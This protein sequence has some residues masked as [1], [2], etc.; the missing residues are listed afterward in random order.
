MSPTG[1]PKLDV[2]ARLKQWMFRRR[3]G[4]FATASEAAGKIARSHGLTVREAQ[5]G[6]KDTRGIEIG[7]GFAERTTFIVTSHGRIAATLGGLAPTDNVIRRLTT[8]RSYNFRPMPICLRSR[9]RL[10]PVR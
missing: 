7:H 3:A 6:R 2:A 9:P 1:T 4:K 5:E 8:Q 10:P